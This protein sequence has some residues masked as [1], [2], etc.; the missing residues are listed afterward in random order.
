MTGEFQSFAKIPRLIR[1]CI[2]TEKLDG[3]NSQVLIEPSYKPRE[4]AIMSVKAE[5]T[6]YSIHPDEPLERSTSC[7]TLY[8]NVYAGS[9]SKWLKPNKQQDNH[10]FAQWV[11]DHVTE[12]V[13]IFGLGRVYGEWWGQGIN[14][15]YGLTEKRFSIFNP[16]FEF[17]TDPKGLVSK[18]PVLYRG[19]FDTTKIEEILNT[20]RE[21]G[22]VA[23]PNYMKPEGL[24]CYHL[25][26]GHLYKRTCENDA[27]WKGEQNG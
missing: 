4:D 10:G 7:H 17:K 3:S 2:C 19:L 16:D 23:V 22:S 27:Q 26:G 12:L 11:Y 24:V 1:E 21:K 8:H 13:R 14:R 9:R 25:A 15:G 18:V 6:I 20:L 5:V